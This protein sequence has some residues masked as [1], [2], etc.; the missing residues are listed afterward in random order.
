[1]LFFGAVMAPLVFIKLPLETA[2][3][4]IRAAFP[5]YYAFIIASSALAAL[6]FFLRGQALSAVV[7]LLLVAVTVWLWVWFLPHLD[8]LRT[9][10]DTLG[11]KRG[12]RLS[13]YVNG[14]ELL[15]A[16]VLL[17]RTAV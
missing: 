15:A 16:L 7:A 3:P 14:A 1:M 4:F 10:G 8:V 13:V 2:G 5:W 11:F 9:A 17:L 12:H 6:G